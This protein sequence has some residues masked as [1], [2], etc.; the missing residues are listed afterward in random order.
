MILH[1]KGFRR[2]P[3]M[4]LMGIAI[5]IVTLPLERANT[6]I[7]DERA[8]DF[9]HTHTG[10]RLNIVYKRGDEYVP[11]ALEEIDVFLSDFRTGD[12]TKIDP[13]LL[14]LI[15]DIR[16]SLGSNGTYEVISAYRSPATNEMLRQRTGSVA[17]NS[18]HLLGKAIDVRLTEIDLRELHAAAIAIQRGGVGYY[19]K[20][21]FVHIDTGRVRRW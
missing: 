10:N 20:S 5:A 9:L 6:A 21:D 8:L 16:E 18:Q 4:V 14:D 19:A 2:G 13:E 7:D 11:E 3:I 17:K 12:I 15:Y 1:T